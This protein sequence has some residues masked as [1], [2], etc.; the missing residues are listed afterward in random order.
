MANVNI[1]VDDALKS[2][3]EKIFSA[4]GLSLST[5]TNV[6]YRQVVRHGGIPFDLSIDAKKSKMDELIELA[7]KKGKILTMNEA[8]SKYP[9]EM[10]F[11]L[12]RDAMF[13][14]LRGRFKMDSDFDAPMEDFKEY[15][16]YES[17]MYRLYGEN[18]ERNMK[19]VIFGIG[20]VGGLVGGLVA[21]SH[22]NTYFYTR[23]ESL[24]VIREQGITV[25]SAQFGNFNARPKLAAD[26][27]G[28]IGV[29]DV[30]FIT[31]KG[32][33]LVEACREA[34][35]MIGENTVVIPL[36]NGVMVSEIMEPL[37]PPCILADGCIFTFCNLVKPGY[38]S[39]QNF[40]KI[41]MGMRSGERLAVLER[42]ADTLN[43]SGITAK[44]SE[45]I[46]I[47]SW[48]KYTIMCGNS[49]IFCT[50]DASAGDVKKIPGYEGVI[51]AIWGEL[52]TVAAAKGV[53]LPEGT[54]DDCVKAF[55]EM[56]PE[57]VTSL[58]RDLRGGKP[59]ERTE[60]A[61]I[62]G[63]MVQFGEETGVP[64]PYHEAALGK[65]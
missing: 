19:I 9:P 37:L 29:A 6:F 10:S 4:L 17:M 60:L 58:Y 45:N 64:V 16:E 21:R 26:S 48:R 41:V 5:A 31:C 11:K 25:D 51:R 52:V 12:S 33:D 2:E 55:E 7:K 34:A 28:E 46:L 50:F 27:A 54:I 14:C 56:T 44:V 38:I 32:Y 42:L 8:F 40:V 49:V 57:T 36:L 3:A 35:P 20:G 47:D 23:G 39:H 59:A 62:I 30:I 65:Y 1:R 43:A 63:R 15:M 24:R 53:A 22:E 18:K 61:H 13:G